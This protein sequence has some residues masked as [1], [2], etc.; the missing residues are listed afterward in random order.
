ML[1]CGANWR[2][3]VGGQGTQLSV[4]SAAG[5]ARVPVLLVLQVLDCRYW[6]CWYVIL[7]VVGVVG[8]HGC[9]I[10]H[11]YTPHFR[12]GSRSPNAP[13]SLRRRGAPFN[14]KNRSLGATRLALRWSHQAHP[15]PCGAEGQ[16]H[17]SPVEAKPSVGITATARGGAR[18]GWG[19][20]GAGLVHS[21][22]T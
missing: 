20:V 9:I 18:R 2:W 21:R 14:P 7:L 15:T 1:I 11:M 5:T 17:Q 16:V 19:S 12:D 6:Y 8:V 10:S 4:F 22:C 13:P 3:A